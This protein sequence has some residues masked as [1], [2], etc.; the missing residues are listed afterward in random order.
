MLMGEAS[1]NCIESNHLSLQN[2]VLQ[3]R[4]DTLISPALVLLV[5]AFMLVYQRNWKSKKIF[6]KTY[7][8]VSDVRNTIYSYF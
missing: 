6:E 5:L 3:I 8:G 2:R 4:M 1:Q 7:K